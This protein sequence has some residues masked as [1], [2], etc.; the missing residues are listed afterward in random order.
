MVVKEEKKK[1][2]T[3]KCVKR[4]SI[5]IGCG[6]SKV[7]AGYEGI[8]EKEKKNRWRSRKCV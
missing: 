6:G 3:R 7:N 2:M 4:R 8:E 1:S 5:G